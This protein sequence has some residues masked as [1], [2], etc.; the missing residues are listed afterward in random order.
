MDVPGGSRQAA[1]RK[2]AD[3]RPP[4]TIAPAHN[5]VQRQ[6]VPY[7]LHSLRHRNDPHVHAA[8]HAH[9]PIVR[10]S[11]QQGQRAHTIQPGTTFRTPDLVG[12][13]VSA[14]M[15]GGGAHL[16]K[17]EKPQLTWAW[18]AALYHETPTQAQ[19]YY[20]PRR[21]RNT[22]SPPPSHRAYFWAGRPEVAGGS[23]HHVQ[24]VS[25]RV[26]PSPPSRCRAAR[27]AA[28]TTRFTTVP[29]TQKALS[30]PGKGLELRKLVAG[31]GFEPATSGL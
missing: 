28:P 16:H 14:I 7:S 20:R 3:P 5:R 15:T 31:A 26:T 4:A 8:L 9:R 1:R 21:L 22:S 11:Q 6:Q 19:V 13:G 12:A 27:R 25:S 29:G 23:V 17:A 18:S 24:A 10:P 2:T 30:L